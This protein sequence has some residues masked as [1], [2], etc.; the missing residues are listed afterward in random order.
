MAKYD[1][2]MT[3]VALTISDNDWKGS[4]VA[5]KQDI[6]LQKLKRRTL[7]ITQC[8]AYTAL[9]IFFNTFLPGDGFSDDFMFRIIKL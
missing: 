1:A 9:C 4:L 5:K 2:G 6:F 8:T 7:V 3:I